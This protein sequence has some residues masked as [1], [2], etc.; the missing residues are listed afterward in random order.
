MPTCPALAGRRCRN[1]VAETR[2]NGFRRRFGLPVSGRPNLFPSAISSETGSHFSG[3]WFE[4]AMVIMNAGLAHAAFDREAR[5][6]A[7]PA[8]VKELSP[9]ETR[10]G[11]VLLSSFARDISLPLAPKPSELVMSSTSIK[12]AM[13]RCPL[14]RGGEPPSFSI[15]RHCNLLARPSSTYSNQAEGKLAT[16]GSRAPSA[17]PII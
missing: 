13:N 14:P 8:I 7:A 10:S 4:S 2:N 1:G 3:E 15:R 12:S 11:S 5:R 16:M 6:H 17:A 9:E